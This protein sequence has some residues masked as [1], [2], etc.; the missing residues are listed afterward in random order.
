MIRLTCWSSRPAA[1]RCCSF[2]TRYAR[3]FS[4]QRQSVRRTRHMNRRPLIITIALVGFGTSVAVAQLSTSDQAEVEAYRSAIRLAESVTSSRGIE[5][6]FSALNPLRE[7]LLRRD[8]QRNGLESMSDEEFNVLRRGLPGTLIN[9]IEV[10]YVR[11]DLA[12]FRRLSEDRGDAADQAFFEALRLTY[13]DSIWP[14]YVQQQTD[15]SGCTRFGSM[16]IVDTYRAW[17]EFQRRFPDRYVAAAR[18]EADAVLRQL[19]G[20]TCACGN[21]AGFRQ[22]LEE[23]IR[24]FPLSPVREIADQRLDDL[25]AGESD[26][27]PGCV[28][29]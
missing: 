27:R 4:T 5:E 26:I 15:Y 16:S 21:T 29:G 17:S 7:A 14:V 25:Q 12:Y 23:F 20:A 19:A 3:P 22:E 2:P 24:S 9:R 11:P 13:P 18:T 10:V 8:D 28:S 1:Q 6:A